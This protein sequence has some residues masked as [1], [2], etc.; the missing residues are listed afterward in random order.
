MPYLTGRVG[1]VSDQSTA[2]RPF[3]KELNLVACS[4]E[5][6]P[7]D[8]VTPAI[9]ADGIRQRVRCRRPPFDSLRPDVEK[10]YKIHMHWATLVDFLNNA[11]G[12]WQWSHII[13]EHSLEDMNVV[14]DGKAVRHMA[15]ASGTV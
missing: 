12:V 6:L 9:P 8:V 15:F 11:A 14:V 7:L 1:H 4:N 5:A 10:N 3:V 2:R 13:C